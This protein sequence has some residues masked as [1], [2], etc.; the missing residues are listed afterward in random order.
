[1]KLE[2][3]IAASEGSGGA[4]AEVEEAKAVLSRSKAKQNGS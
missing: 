1:M 4:Q 2:D 3:A